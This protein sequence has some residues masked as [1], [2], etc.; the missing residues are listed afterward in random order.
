LIKSGLLYGSETWRLTESNKRRAEATEIDALR[1]SS[2]ISRR[3]KI[4]NVTIRQQIGLEETIIKEIEQNQLTWYGHVQRIAEGRLPKIAL[5]LMSKTEESTRK[6]EEEL[7]GRNKEGHERKK[8][9]RRPVG[10]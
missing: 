5:K 7:D 3:D 6:T 4:R 1:R 8:P 2:R 9:K 10:R